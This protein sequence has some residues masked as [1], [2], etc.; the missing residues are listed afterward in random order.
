VSELLSIDAA[1]ARVDAVCPLLPAESLP[2]HQALGRVLAETARARCD[3]PPFAQSA[4]D[5]Y[6]LRLADCAEVP[7]TLRLGGVVAAA[8]QDGAVS[9]PSGHALRIFTGALVPPDADAVVQQEWTEAGDGIV[10]VLRAPRLGQNIRSQGEELEAG[11]PLA[12]P[13]TRLTPGLLA[14]LSAAGVANVSVRRAPR[15]HV[16]VTGDEIVPVGQTLRPGEVY[17]ANG[18]LLASWFALLGLPAPAVH[19]VGDTDEAVTEALQRGF[20]EADLVLTTGGVSV[21]DKDLI[22]PVAERLGAERVLWK[23]AQKPGKP[24]YVAR[25]GTC[26]L[27]GL[28]GNP[29]SVL[30]N[31]CVFARRALDRMQGVDPAGPGWAMGQLAAEAR[32]DAQRDSWLRVRVEHDADGVARLY[33][34]S[35]QASHMLS[36]LAAADGLA[37]LP[38]GDTAAS[39]TRLRWQPLFG[40]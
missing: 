4:M 6:A 13:G 40:G 32:A 37:W 2:L 28:P 1:L 3:L 33:P 8:R 15:V 39:G 26:L 18:I 25:R 11:T 30:V 31:L 20:A 34:L 27:M 16:L 29:A 12:A 7:A 14:S 22:A 24:L 10:R 9:I 17:D 19:H 35:H 5:G 36:N 38:A 21:G 23:V